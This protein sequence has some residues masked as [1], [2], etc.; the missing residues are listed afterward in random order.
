[1]TFIGEFKDQEAALVNLIPSSEF[2]QQK[3][4]PSPS[5]AVTTLPLTTKASNYNNNDVQDKNN[6]DAELRALEEKLET[7]K[8]KLEQDLKQ[9]KLRR[10]KVEQELELLKSKYIYLCYNAMLK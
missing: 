4:I 3:D 8:K 1:M 9:E 6:N 7:Q 2:F 10:E 5:S